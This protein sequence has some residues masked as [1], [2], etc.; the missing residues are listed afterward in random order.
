MSCTVEA[1]DND[2]AQAIAKILLSNQVVND[3]G[4]DYGLVGNITTR[5]G[6][7]IL[8]SNTHGTI[9]LPVTAEGVWVYKWSDAQKQYLAGQ[10]AGK[11]VQNAKLLLN[12]QKGADAVKLQLSRGDNDMLPSDTS[13]ITVNVVAISGL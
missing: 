7:P 13:H 11:S 5:V 4:S 9:S 2:G 8:V 10:L 3:L 12:R 1:Y 6:Q